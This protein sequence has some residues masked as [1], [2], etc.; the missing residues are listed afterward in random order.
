MF[1]HECTLHLIK[2][3]QI[4]E[5]W[6]KFYEKLDGTNL[7][8]PKDHWA[9]NLET[10]EVLIIDSSSNGVLIGDWEE[11][12]AREVEA[13]IAFERDARERMQ[14]KENESGGWF[15]DSDFRLLN[16]FQH[17]INRLS[18]LFSISDEKRQA[19]WEEAKDKVFQR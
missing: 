11:F 13:M 19:I 16:M 1:R 14:C 8:D 9:K 3:G 6:G 2:P 4:F 17:R 15:S 5:Y 18:L 7:E 12:F 10:L